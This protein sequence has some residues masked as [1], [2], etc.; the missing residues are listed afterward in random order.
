M[1]KIAIIGCGAVAEKAH[2]PAIATAEE[3]RATV[4]VDRNRERAERLAQQFRISHV[5]EDYREVGSEAAAAIV[6]PMCSDGPQSA[7]PMCFLSTFTIRR[8]AHGRYPR[9]L[10]FQ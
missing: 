10:I 2:L 1:F 7:S 3:A 8:F 5:A 6:A 4:L 9:M